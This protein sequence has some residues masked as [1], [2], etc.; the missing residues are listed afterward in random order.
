MMKTWVVIQ[1]TTD[2]EPYIIVTVT[3]EEADQAVSE[4]IRRCHGHDYCV[5]HDRIGWICIAQ[6]QDK[7]INLFLVLLWIRFCEFEQHPLNPRPAFVYDGES[8]PEHGRIHLVKCDRFVTEGAS[9]LTGGQS[10]AQN[11]TA[12]VED[13]QCRHQESDEE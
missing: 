11:S 7:L 12:A 3:C 6:I 4:C 1:I 9:G 13:E 5:S 2:L 8:A 10:H